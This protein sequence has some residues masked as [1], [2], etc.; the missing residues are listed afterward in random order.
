M[1]FY[2]DS[3]NN[4]VKATEKDLFDKTTHKRDRNILLNFRRLSV[5]TSRSVKNY[6]LE[7]FPGKEKCC[8]QLKNGNNRGIEAEPDKYYFRQE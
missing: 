3:S 6:I 1:I 2:I 5:Y 8:L 4:N 7:L